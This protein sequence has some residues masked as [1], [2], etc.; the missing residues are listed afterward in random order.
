MTK[1]RDRRLREYS[2]EN[3]QIREQAKAQREVALYE[4]RDPVKQYIRR[5]AW[6]DVIAEYVGRLREAGVERPWKYLTLP[7]EFASDIGLLWQHNLLDKTSE[8]KLSVAICDNK[9]A[10]TVAGKL[11]RFG[12][13][14]SYGTRDI[15][16][17]LAD[18]R[19]PLKNAFPFDVINL[20]LCNPLI[21]PT[22]DANLRTIEEIFKL[23]RGQAFLLLLTT[24]PEP[25]A[26][27]RLTELLV[28][29]ITDEEAF[30][31]IY[32]RVYRVTEPEP[33]LRNYTKFTQIVFPKAIAR[34]ARDRGYRCQELYVARYRRESRKGNYDMIVH[35]FE[36][37]PLGIKIPEKAYTTRHS[38]VA[39]TTIEER[40]RNNLSKAVRQQADDAYLTFT[41]SL[42][43]RSSLDASRVLIGNPR[44]EQEL[45]D[46]SEA[47][48]AWCQ[49]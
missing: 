45:G 11:Q 43:E 31:E 24:K 23:Q 13:I 3:K 46:E 21:P 29:N 7:G 20:D 8:G 48:A 17:E 14:L 18:K 35:S 19:S 27:E 49:Q 25:Y 26:R 30:R 2:Q 44:L 16:I 37:Q 41:C 10:E 4:R 22:N 42:L 32:R 40:L 34:W 6:L 12:G 1:K 5:H 39:E 15:D 9:Y 36:F 28:Q 38:R 33:C 47:L